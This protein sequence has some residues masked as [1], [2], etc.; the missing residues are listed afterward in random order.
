MEQWLKKDDNSISVE[1]VRLN[2]DNVAEVAQWCRA[3]MVE[4]TDLEH[5]DEMQMGLNVVTPSGVQRASLGMYVA[6]FGRNFFVSNVRP[7]EL[8]YEPANRPSPPP[9]STADARRRLGFADPFDMGRFG[10]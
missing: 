4:E 10:P 1:A 9:E 8:L 2:E 6:K 5:P 3:G 7:F